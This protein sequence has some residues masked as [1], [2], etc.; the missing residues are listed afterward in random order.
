MV[1]E[2][3]FIPDVSPPTYVNRIVVLPST[4]TTWSSGVGD[5]AA[6]WTY[7]VMAVDAS[8]QELARSNRVGEADFETDTR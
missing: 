7:L 1:N 8:E 3:W 2:P 4:T 6:N 5:P